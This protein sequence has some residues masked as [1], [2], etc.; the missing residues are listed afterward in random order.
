MGHRNAQGLYFDKENNFILE[1]EHGPM[2]GDEI[3]LNRTPDINN[4][5]NFGWAVSSYGDHY[6]N[7]DQKA[8]YNVAPLNKSHIDYGFIEPLKWFTP[9]L[10]ISQIIKTEN[11]LKVNNKHVI[12][13]GAL[14]SDLKEGDLSI[15]QFVLNQKF[16][17][18]NHII[19]PIGERVRD[20][21]YIEELN[22]IFTYL[23]SSSSIAIIDN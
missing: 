23:E 13:V 18:E 8:L 4:I 9:A 20:I 2:G 3:N 6:T 22:K 1:T 21:I 17:I 19:L 10:G 15:H 11:L 14:G 16:E 12:Y 7:L 5:K